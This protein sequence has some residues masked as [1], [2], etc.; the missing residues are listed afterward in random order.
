MKYLFYKCNS[1]KNV[2][3]ISKWDTSSVT[4]M[5]FMLYECSSLTSLSE[6]SN[7]KTNNAINMDSKFLDFPI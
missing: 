3:V 5:S 4:D 6:I 2:L 7:S 1:L